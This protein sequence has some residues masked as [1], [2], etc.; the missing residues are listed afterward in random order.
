MKKINTDVSGVYKIV[1][2]VNDK[3]YIGSTVNIRLRWNGH[4]SQ[5]NRGVHHSIKLQRAWGK[6]GESSFEFIV[7]SFCGVEEMFDIEQSYLDIGFKKEK[8][9]LIYNIADSAYFTAGDRHF[10]YGKTHSEK[11]KKLIREARSRQII[12]H[13]EETKNKI[14]EAHKGRIQ[15]RTSVEKAIKTKLFRFANSITVPWNKGKNTDNRLKSVSNDKR[16]KL[17]IDIS[18]KIIQLY[19][20]E[21]RSIEFIRKQFKIDWEVVKNH[22][23]DNGIG[24]RNISQQKKI[25]DEQENQRISKTVKIGN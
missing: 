1:N 4:K 19:I 21:K 24:T 17:S 9:K 22:L 18:S 7:V 3:Y 8:K 5:L 13:S 23:I 11:S 25:R 14:G 12:K 16:M 6:Y 10:M 2:K 15:N 20:N